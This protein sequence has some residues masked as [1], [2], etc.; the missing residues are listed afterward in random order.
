MFRAEMKTNYKTNYHLELIDSRSGEKKQ[1][2]DTSNVFTI[3][4]WNAALYNYGSAGAPRFV[5]NIYL[6]SGSGT[7][8]ESDTAMFKNLWNIGSDSETRTADVENK[9]IHV[10]ASASFP[11]T[12]SYVGT[13]TEVGIWS[14]TCGGGSSWPTP[15]MMTHALLK[16]AEGNPISITKS[17]TD[18]LKVTVVLD[19]S[20]SV[21]SPWTLNKYPGYL[22]SV[23]RSSVLRNQWMNVYFSL[24]TTSQEPRNYGNNYGLYHYPQPTA[25]LGS[26][27]SMNKATKKMTFPTARNEVAAGSTRPIYYN[28]AMFT[29]FCYVALPNPDIFPSY[30]VSG[31]RIGTGDGNATQFPNPMNYYVKDTET[32]YKNGNALVR[33][34]DYTI[35]YRNNHNRLPE[36]APTKNAKL[37]GG[38][39][40]AAATYN[41]HK[42][43]LFQRMINNVNAYLIDPVSVGWTDVAPLTIEFEDSG[44]VNT[45]FIPS[46]VVTGVITLSHSA[47]GET[48]TQ[49]CQVNHTSGTA[50][51]E[52]FSKVNAKFWKIEGT[53]TKWTTH[54]FTTDV[55]TDELFLGYVGDPYITFT[56]AP[57]DGDVITMDVEMDRPFKNGNFVIDVQAEL[58]MS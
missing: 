40:L 50:N 33:G 24:G 23:V 13:I 51:T 5:T 46:W 32:I 14:S 10:V 7:P 18:I 3:G 20:Y 36:L 11:A 34:T 55:M 6:G 29:G 26:T 28:Y 41:G 8:A 2:V 53:N 17:D 15:V 12:S 44:D 9:S 45:F 21:S 56:E 58:Q 38:V 16:D 57:A 27:G 19:I 39:E 54:N 25:F 47:D 37:T 49:A 30:M 22:L 4:W 43:M 42:Q 1:E 52:T 35:D 48:W 31:I